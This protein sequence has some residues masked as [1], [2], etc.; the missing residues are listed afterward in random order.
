MQPNIT[1]NYTRRVNIIR[2]TRIKE[3]GGVQ[4]EG[5][6]IKSIL[7]EDGQKISA[8]IFIDASIEG[9]LI[10]LA[11]ITTQAIREGNQLYDETSV[12]VF[13]L[14]WLLEGEEY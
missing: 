2:K 6:T 12:A 1:T 4:K 13:N 14:R 10:H 5:T 8:K 11:G 9:H 7:L 3:Y